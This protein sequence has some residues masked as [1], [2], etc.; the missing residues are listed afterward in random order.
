MP[1]LISIP[2]YLLVRARL[3]GDIEAIFP[4]AEVVEGAGTD[5]RFRTTVSRGRFREVLDELA[6]GIDY[7]NFKAS[8]RDE[9]LHDMYL[10][11]WQAAYQAQQAA[12][13][14]N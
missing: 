9:A 11:F 8:V 13:K 12:A 1:S 7:T 4:E 14:A 10:D 2:N 5:Y 3:P 6:D